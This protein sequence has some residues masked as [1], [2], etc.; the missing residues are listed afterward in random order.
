MDFSKRGTANKQRDVNSTSQK[1][2]RKALISFLRTCIVC[3]VAIS[4]IGTFTGLGALKG[5]IDSATSIDEIDV[6]PTGFS[7][8]IYDSEGNEIQKLVGSQANRIYVTLDKIPDNVINAFIAI[9]DE[10]FW[11]CDSMLKK[12]YCFCELM[13]QVE[14]IVA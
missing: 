12:K 1:I 6:A 13:M 2:S 4:I 11:T 7:T 10:R 14:V 3:V 5:M 9:E 8:I